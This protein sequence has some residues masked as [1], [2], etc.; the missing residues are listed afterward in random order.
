MKTLDIIISPEVGTSSDTRDVDFPHIIET[1]EGG[2][3]SAVFEFY[4]ALTVRDGDD[5][6][7]IDTTDH[8]LDEN[9]IEYTLDTGLGGREH[10]VGD[11]RFENHQ[12]FAFQP[13]EHRYLFRVNAPRVSE[14]LISEQYAS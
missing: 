4:D 7:D 9:S 10:P 11:T 12:G 14:T 1:E 8:D 13:E 3:T 6:V 2:L 5:W